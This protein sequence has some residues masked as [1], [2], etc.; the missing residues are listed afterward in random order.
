MLILICG[1]SLQKYVST[2]F[3]KRLSLKRLPSK[4]ISFLIHMG[5]WATR[6]DKKYLVSQHKLYDQHTVCG[7]PEYQ[8][9]NN[10]R[11]RPSHSAHFSTTAQLKWSWGGPLFEIKALLAGFRSAGGIP[12]LVAF[13]SL[14]RA[15]R[16]SRIRVIAVRGISSV[17]RSLCRTAAGTRCAWAS[18]LPRVHITWNIRP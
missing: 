15:L 6:N 9:R 1:F 14:I 4:C 8:V 16:I 7:Y 12:T 17:I 13:S 5:K 11:A 10:P 18:I 3:L 2:E